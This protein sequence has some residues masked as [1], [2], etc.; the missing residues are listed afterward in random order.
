MLME[1]GRSSQFIVITH[2]KKTVA[3]ASTLLGVTME[4]NGVS[5]VV[6]IRI[7][8]REEVHAS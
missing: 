6:A 8:G 2:N 5:K 3:S 4:E 1:F 7:G